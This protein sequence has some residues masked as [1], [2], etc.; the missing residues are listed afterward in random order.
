MICPICL[1][2]K[3]KLI[4]KKLRYDIKRNVWQCSQ[5]GLAFLEPINEDADY[6]AGKKYRRQYGPNLRRRVDHQEIFNTYL[7]AQREI[8]KAVKKIL[9]P[10]MRVLDVGCSTGHFLHSLRGLVAQRIGVELDREAVKFVKN[11]L[12]FK[13]YD[14][15]LGKLKIAEAP[16]D[17][18]TSFQ[19]LEHIEDP[20]FFLRQIAKNLKSDGWLYLEVPN[21]NDVLLGTYQIPGY[22]DFYF[23]EPH[24]Y[25]FSLPA[26]KKLLA[27]AGFVGEFK[28]VQRYSL[29]NHLHWFLTGRPQDSFEI[30]TAIPELVK[31][32]SADRI[33]KRELN[34][35]IKSVDSKYKQLLV[36]R[37][38]G[39]S[40][41]FLGKKKGK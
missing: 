23:R 34:S 41:T 38:L 16:F 12:D 36:K 19:V 10:T 24:L 35:F 26:L 1:A 22:A 6:Y 9:K 5:C 33:T 30:G 20:L 18:V 32:S 37:G 31:S 40:I 17:L 14:K 28:T 39:E 8:I 15:P 25:Y 4:R 3:S 2:K 11:K 29:F 27:R 21:V 7:P 13:I